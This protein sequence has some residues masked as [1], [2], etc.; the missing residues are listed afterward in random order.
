[1]IKV[2]NKTLANKGREILKDIVT[3]LPEDYQAKFKKVYRGKISIE[4]VD[5]MSIEEIVGLIP[6]DFIDSAISLSE[7]SLE[8]L[9]R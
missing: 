4:E 2:M 8:K 1:M 7:R 6:E 5:K 9:S 3:K